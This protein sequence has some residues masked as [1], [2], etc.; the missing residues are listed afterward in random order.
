MKKVAILTIQSQN[1]GNRLQNYALQQAICT[2][3]YKCET[4]NRVVDKKNKLN[5]I[6]H[7]LR[8]KNN[9]DKFTQFD[10]KI[11][12]S[13]DI[14]CIE[15]VSDDL[16]TKYDCFVIGSDQIWNVDFYF[17][18][19]LD[20][21]P[22]VTKSKKVAYAASFGINSIPM[23]KQDFVKFGLEN[24]NMLSVREKKG[25]D[26]ISN[27]TG[28]NAQCVLDP[29]LLLSSKEWDMI[30]VKPKGFVERPYI[31]TY[32]LGN[33]VYEAEIEKIKHETGYDVIDIWN[34][35]LVCGPSEFVYLI[36]NAKLVCTDSYHATIFSIIYSIPFL[37][38]DR[39]GK[40]EDMSS[41]IDSLLEMVSMK[42]RKYQK[43]ELNLNRIMNTKYEKVCKIIEDEKKKSIIYLEKAF[44]EV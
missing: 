10:M 31:F 37:I 32:Y 25:I 2:L 26:I 6:L 28:L 16:E 4:L 38:F 19:E 22:M 11:H 30:L 1:Y 33:K 44:L 23:E 36:K 13:K 12:W 40:S 39:V 34:T 43:G 15:S 29:T 5:R 20:F 9:Y 14:V 27:L 8:N 3:G 41:R 18:S 7:C 17:T 24:I 35:N 21:L 42:D